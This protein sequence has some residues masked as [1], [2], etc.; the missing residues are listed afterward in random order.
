MTAPKASG[1]DAAIGERKTSR[2]TI[3]RKGS[4]ISSPR[5]VGVDRFLLD[6][7]REAGVAGLGRAHRGVDVLF[8]H[9]SSCGTVSLTA[10]FD[11][12]VEV[13]EDQR[14]VGRR[15]AAAA[16]GP[17]SQGESV[18]TFGSSRRARTSSGPWRSSAA[19][20]PRSRIAK[21]AVSPK[22]SRRIWLLRAED[23][24]RG[25]RAW[26][27]RAGRSTPVPITAE[28]DEDDRRHRRGRRGGGAAARLL[29]PESVSAGTVS[30]PCSSSFPPW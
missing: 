6:R 17:V 5:S 13:G 24:C 28:R 9:R 8:E 27:G 12:D 10:V 26:S 29:V 2:R 16:T 18:V 3:S 25:C 22:C 19:A 11:V 14:P 30:F 23:A 4:A 20:G 1:I 15:A 21:G 7:P